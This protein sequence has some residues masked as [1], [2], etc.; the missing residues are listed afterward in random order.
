MSICVCVCIWVHKHTLVYSLIPFI[1]KQRKSWEWLFQQPTIVSEGAAAQE[2]VPFLLISWTWCSK[3]VFL[4]CWKQQNPM[5]GLP[6]AFQLSNDKGLICTQLMQQYSW[7]L[8][9][10]Q[11]TEKSDWLRSAPLWFLELC[12]SCKHWGCSRRWCQR[13]KCWSWR[14][15]GRCEPPFARLQQV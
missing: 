13:E 1:K 7:L 8:S 12:F 3:A 14:C 5:V 2:P 15:R 4:F 11:W 6:S 9:Y 10:L